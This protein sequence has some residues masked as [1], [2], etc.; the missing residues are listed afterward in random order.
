MVFEEPTMKNYSIFVIGLCLLFSAIGVST[1]SYAF[2]K[3]DLKKLKKTK[4]CERCDLSGAIIKLQQL[5][6]AKLSGADLS[7]AVLTRVRLT[8]A[9]LSGANLTGAKLANTQLDHANLTGA[10]LTNVRMDITNVRHADFK[11]AILVGLITDD[12]TKEYFERAK[13]VPTGT[14]A[15][16]KKSGGL[17]TSELSVCK[18]NLENALEKKQLF[19]DRWSAIVKKEMEYKQ[20]IRKWKLE[21]SR[22]AEYKQLYNDAI[23]Q[24]T[25]LQD[26]EKA[27]KTEDEQKDV[28]NTY[29]AAELGLMA[30][31]LGIISENYPHDYWVNVWTHLRNV[32]DRLGL[33]NGH[34]EGI[35]RRSNK[36]VTE[37]SVKGDLRSE[38]VGGCVANGEYQP[39]KN[40]THKELCSCM[41]DQIIGNGLI[42][43]L[44]KS[45][46][47]MFSQGGKGAVKGTA[48]EGFLTT[49]HTHCAI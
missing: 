44:S 25:G 30:E 16:K 46:K 37:K 34:L 1:Q 48:L 47:E 27:R 28:T 9:D 22:N 14:V 13:N 29:L 12:K 23:A 31:D 40:Q 49:F 8:K 32:V 10:N 5:T 18:G 15:K 41:A 33:Y 7:G 35:E 43:V 6:G 2:S 19:S 21:A 11:D 17:C 3:D 24:N 38:F 36:S 45:E 42:G 4:E 26:Q 20:T 39:A